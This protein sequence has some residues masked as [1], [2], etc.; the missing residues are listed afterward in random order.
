LNLDQH[1]IIKDITS[2]YPLDTEEINLIYHVFKLIE[3]NRNITIFENGQRMNQL[4]FIIE[5]LVKLVFI[6]HN[7]K[8][9]IIGFAVENWWETD[10][11]AFFY[12]QKTSYNLVTMEKTK[13]YAITEMDYKMIINKIPSLKSYFLDKSIRGFFASQQRVL[14]LLSMDSKNRYDQLLKL[15]PKWFQRIPK[16][17]IATYLG[18]SRET[19][20]RMVKE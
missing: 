19:L 6:D 16:K 17:Y 3:Y 7:G 20:S 11:G 5:G 13:L 8:E 14:S 12:Q 9:F 1:P 18:V 15:Y 4:Y 10:V 2:L